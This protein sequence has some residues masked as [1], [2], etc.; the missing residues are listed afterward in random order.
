LVDPKVQVFG[1][2][3][4]ST[5]LL[6]AA[7]AVSII[8]I[9]GVAMGG[10]LVVEVDTVMPVIGLAFDG[11]GYTGCNGVWYN[12]AAY[13]EVN[14][15]S[16]TNLNAGIDQWGSLQSE[17]HNCKFVGNVIGILYSTQTITYYGGLIPPNR[18]L[19]SWCAFYGSSQHAIDFSGGAQLIINE[20]EFGT[21]G[22]VGD[23]T[24][25]AIWY[26][27]SDLNN[28]T[29]QGLVLRGG[30]ME[31]NVGLAAIWIDA[32][33]HAGS[34]SISDTYFPTNDASYAVYIDGSSSAQY[35]TCNNMMIANAA[36]TRGIY[37]TGTTFVDLKNSTGILAGSG[38]VIRQDPLLDQTNISDLSQMSALRLP[39]LSTTERNALTATSGMLI[40]NTT[41]TQV[42]RYTSS[43]A[44]VG[45]SGGSGSG[46]VIA[47][48]SAT[49]GNLVVFG[50]DPQHILDGGAPAGGGGSGSWYTETHTWT[51]LSADTPTFIADTD[52][53]LT[54]IISVGMKLIL[55]QG[56][57]KFFIITAI[58]STTVTMYGG[59][60]YTLTSDPITAVYYSGQKAPFGFPLDPTK[61]TVE[62]S[63]V[64][65]RGPVTSTTW[66]N[67]DS[68]GISVPI[69]LWNLKYYVQ[70]Y[71]DSSDGNNEMNITLSTSIDGESDPDFTSGLASLNAPTS[72]NYS[73]LEMSLNRDKTVSVSVNTPYYLN[74]LKMA[75]MN[76]F[77]RNQITKMIIRA[78]CVYM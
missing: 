10:G 47:P 41:T 77:L 66:T 70:P 67:V 46:D 61:W 57:D 33:T 39:N 16:F 71:V 65:Q 68:L 24:T 20:C 63:D 55:V 31:G 73:V 22:T 76:V 12:G 2:G 3:Y 56:T 11:N 28:P 50:S 4:R 62:V 8:E 51:Y 36:S 5:K 30:W 26:H 72:G 1:N 78:V 48:V 14:N 21:N 37:R 69:G 29:A 13:F 52:S 60:D 44:S 19:V 64:I 49:P 23:V 43:W 35:L 15:C 7:N 32:S 59:T 42:E 18:V 25:A 6:A 75:G 27:A 53:D 58:D 54:G 38:G 9:A 74:V 40:Y 45:G 34:H 17:V